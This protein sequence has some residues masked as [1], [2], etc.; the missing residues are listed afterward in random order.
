MSEYLK[1]YA[2]YIVNTAHDPL[3]NEMFDDDWEP[4]GP[5]LRSDLVKAGWITQ[6]D[7]G[8]RLTDVGREAAASAN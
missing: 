3:S 4:I 8:V 5:A 6:S 2:Q 1:R 7:D